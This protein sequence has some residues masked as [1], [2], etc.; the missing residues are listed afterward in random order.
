M[1]QLLTVVYKQLLVHLHILF[2]YQWAFLIVFTILLLPQFQWQI[3]IPGLV[4]WRKSKVNTGKINSIAH[5]QLH[6]SW[7]LT[8]MIQ[9]ISQNLRFNWVHMCMSFL[10]IVLYKMEMM[11]NGS[12]ETISLL[13]TDAL[14]PNPDPAGS[15]IYGSDRIRIQKKNPASVQTRYPNCTCASHQSKAN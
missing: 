7:F 1:E 3:F 13:S 4:S 15:E 8:F 11:T 2:H 10:T 9:I 6:T 14:D 5:L 12:S